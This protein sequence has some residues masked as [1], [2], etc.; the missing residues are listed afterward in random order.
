MIMEVQFYGQR[1]FVHLLLSGVFERF[2]NLKFVMT[3]QGCAWVPPMLNHLDGMLGNIRK[4]KAVGELRFADEHILPKSATEYFH[5]NC[6]MGVSQPGQ[7]DAAARDI[8]GLDRFMWGSDYPHDE[9]T[10]PFTREH[11][12]QVF[13][14]VD[15]TLM[16]NLLAGN[17]ATLYGFDLD[18]LAPIAA[19]H[20]PTVDE[21]AEPL[22]ELPEKPNEALKR[23]MVPAGR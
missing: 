5:Q 16:R 2:P 23:G 3:E 9:G 15:S 4:N 20:G 8:I 13:H 11:L 10:Y 22:T 7:A 17:A 18:K 6:W 14:G 1:P 19:A 12:R 21:I